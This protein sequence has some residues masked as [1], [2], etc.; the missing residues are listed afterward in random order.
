MIYTSVKDGDIELYI[1]DLKSG[2][3][4]RITNTLGYDGGAWFSPDGKDHLAR[5]PPAKPKNAIKKYKD[6]LAEN[7]V[8]PTNM[9]VVCSC[10]CARNAHQV[11]S[12]RTG[13]LGACFYA[14]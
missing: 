6:L 8:A 12:L 11:T 1:M 10:R 5:F 3:E 9:E 14:R 13:Q 2:K 4:K 7:L